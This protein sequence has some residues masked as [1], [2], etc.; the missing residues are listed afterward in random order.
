LVEGVPGEATAGPAAAA[1]HPAPGTLHDPVYFDEAPEI[2]GNSVVSINCRRALVREIRTPRSVGTGGGRP[3]P[4]TRWGGK[5]GDAEWPK[6]LRPS[7]TLPIPLASYLRE[8]FQVFK[9][10]SKRRFDY[11]VH[12]ENVFCYAAAGSS[13]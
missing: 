3:P 13:P 9:E 2:S 8:F 7:L 6:P 11:L 4:V 5:Q 10:M 12:G 1:Q